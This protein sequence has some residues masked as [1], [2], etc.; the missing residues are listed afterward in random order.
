MQKE[1]EE[2]VGLLG[3]GLSLA[4]QTAA[5]PSDK[6]YWLPGSLCFKRRQKARLCAESCAD[7]FWIWVVL[8]FITT[9]SLG[10]VRSCGM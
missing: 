7:R 4:A 8:L 3:F 2:V 5:T 10:Q 6:S 1:G 9:V